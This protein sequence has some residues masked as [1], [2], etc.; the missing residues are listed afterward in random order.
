MSNTE[1]LQDNSVMEAAAN[2]DKE[3]IAEVAPTPSNA[4]K[5]HERVDPE[6]AETEHVNQNEPEALHT[7]QHGDGTSM[8]SF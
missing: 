6:A 8:G 2:H 1:T 7:D 5:N 4:F 3:I